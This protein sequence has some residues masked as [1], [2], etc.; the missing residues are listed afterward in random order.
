MAPALSCYFRG[1]ADI[2]LLE[3][4]EKKDL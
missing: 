1:G 2:L 4:P 3:K